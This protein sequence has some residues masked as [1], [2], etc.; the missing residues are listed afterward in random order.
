MR[1]DA[2]FCAAVERAIAAGKETAGV[3]DHPSRREKKRPQD[4][5]A[6]LARMRIAAARMGL[7]G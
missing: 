2:D 7:V 4:E 3:L 1:M 6:R 5:G